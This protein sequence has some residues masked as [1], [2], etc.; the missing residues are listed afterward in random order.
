MSTLETAFFDALGFRESSNNYSANSN[1]YLGKYQLGEGSLIDQGYVNN[2]GTN[3]NDYS[4]GWTGKDGVYSIQEF[5][6]NHSAQENAVRGYAQTNWNTIRNL[7][8]DSYVGNTINGIKI[9][10]SGL[11]AGMHLLGAGDSDGSPLGLRHFLES[12][13]S[14][15]PVDGN[16][17][18]V[19]EYLQQFQDFDMFPPLPDRKPGQPEDPTPTSAPSLPQSPDRPDDQGSP[20]VLDLDGDGIELSPLAESAT[21]FDLRGNGQAVLTGWVEPDDGLLAL[22]INQDGFINDVTELFGT[23]T[24]DGFTVLAAHDGNADAVIDASDAVFAD[25]LIWR[26]LNSD[27]L[28][29]S[30]EL[31]SLADYNIT[32]INLEAERL[33]K[34]SIA[35][36]AITHEASYT[37]TGGTTR[38][39]VDAWFTYDVQNTVNVQDYVWD[40]RTL[41]L[42]TLR[43][44]GDLKDLHIAASL[45]NAG[46]GNL[47]D[48]IATLA[49]DMDFATAL[50]D[51]SPTTAALE[52]ILFRWAGIEAVSPTGRG[53]YV[54]GQH[55]AFNEAI[56]GE[57]FTQY[58]SPNPL[59]E[60]G[61]YSEAVYQYLL[62]FYTI[63][64]ITQA[65]GDQLFAAPSYNL[66]TGEIEGDL[67]L[68]QAGIDA[69]KD[70]AIA[71][72]DGT[73]VWTRFAQFLGY[74]KGLANLTAGEITAL[75]TAVAATAEPSLSDWQ[76]VVTAMSVTLGAIIDSADDWGSFE[77]YYDNYIDGTSGDDTLVDTNIG[78]LTDNEFYGRDGADTI[79]ALDGHDKLVG[80]AGN[81]TLDGGA[82]DDF[83]LGG[84]GDDQYIY[85]SGNDTI[86]EEGGG[87]TDQLHI[88]AST[89]LISSNLTDLYRQGDELT[90]LLST[91]A[92]ITIHGY[93][94][95][96][97]K[98]ETIVFDADSSQIDLTALTEEKFYGTSG[99]DTLVLQ[100]QNYQTLTAYGYAGN[101]TIE[102]SGSAGKFY[103]GDGYDTLI[104]DFANDRLE[105]ENGDDYLLGLA[106]A[107][108]LLGGAGQDWAKGGDGADN[109]NGGDDDDT[110]FGEAGNDIISGGRGNDIIDG[111]AGDDTLYGLQ[112]SGIAYTQDGD[113][114]FIYGLGY[115]N[116]RIELT[117]ENDDKIVFLSSIAPG[118]LL[119]QRGST[120]STEDDLILRIASSSETL[121][122]EDMFIYPGGHWDGAIKTFEFSNGTMWTDA[123][124]RAAYLA[125]NITSGND[126]TKGFRDANDIASSGGNDTLRGLYGGDTYHWGTGVGND[127]I[128]EAIESNSILDHLYIETLNISDLSFVKSG[129]HL[130]LTNLATNETITI[131]DQFKTSQLIERFHFLDGS[132]MTNTQIADFTINN[133]PIIGTS[134]DDLLH[135]QQK[136]NTISGLA[137]N[138]SLSG[139][140]GNDTLEGGTGNDTLDGGDGT[141]TVRYANAASGV[142]VNLTTGAASGGDGS[143]TLSGIE[144]IIG[145]A[146]ADTLTGSGGA[147]VIYGGAGNDTIYAGAGNDELYGDEGDDTVYGNENDDAIYGGSGADVLSGQD[148]NDTIRGEA[149]IDYIVGGAGADLIYGGDDDDEAYGGDDN[150]EIHGGA[151]VDNLLGEAGNDTLYG[152]D[153]NDFLYGDYGSTSGG[154]DILYGGAGNDRLEGRYGDDTIYGESGTDTI[155]GGAGADTIDGGSENDTIYGED[156]NDAIAG[157]AG[158][159]A[160]YGGT[161]TDVIHGNDNDD[162]LRGEADND[163]LYGDSGVDTLYGGDGADTL[164]GDAGNDI[165]R[166]EAGADIMYGGDGNDD[167][168]GGDGDDSIY[169]NAG[170]DLLYGNAGV[171]TFIF[172]DLTHTGYDSLW[173]FTDEAGG[174]VLDISALL[175]DYDPLT[176]AIADFVSVSVYQGDTLIKVDQDGTG[177]SYA[178]TSVVHLRGAGDAGNLADLLADA[179][180]KIAA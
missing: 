33:A 88:A 29:Q 104:G 175:H 109:I 83:M 93:N 79:Q 148:G 15:D 102:A 108:V 110:I 141:D 82:G 12:N 117:L 35:G 157:G 19:S 179:N 177:S 70:E 92:S 74:T 153:G 167:V 159:D 44:M 58:G 143:D 114:T 43:G 174:D 120:I 62:T 54:D 138:D 136:D 111:G 85:V 50:G 137:G 77:I 124:I 11:I 142:T 135:G 23:A 155:Y 129:N 178:M 5:L 69:V 86:S 1:G 25:L 154:N 64:I 139:G 37:M 171:D 20:L 81:D 123:S 172:N 96:N 36:N 100:G 156:G 65:A 16:G 3:N 151:G 75:D 42:P 164:Y 134:A 51:W 121:T 22:D 166:G 180:L 47:L 45:D 9:T 146:Y 158:N 40:I 17:T 39:I 28:S 41:F 63:Q 24:V 165:M 55:L 84:L 152:D 130:I 53:A 168:R 60:A 128:V 119:I 145:S 80:G 126:D 106:G 18:P 30:A 27:G 66:Y 147:N 99:F 95:A 113:D 14:I 160:I 48:Q 116:D 89:G 46:A 173:D 115:G 52:A 161:G 98:I 57:A 94:G 125:A 90:L 162:T 132:V 76:D 10:P 97:T 87:G 127:T 101:D 31:F 38:T 105:G 91:G 131:N 150:D 68:L 112:A 78:G 61:V 149:G 13:G 122:V 72:V 170:S 32:G 169:G 34:T 7:G 133:N 49:T 144:N 6:S 56:R 59:P 140:A 103:G 107:D 2:D 67:T 8:L 26:D 21:Y 71:A 176:E 73:A 118:D 4:G 163:T